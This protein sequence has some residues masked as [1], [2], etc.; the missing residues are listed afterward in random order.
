MNVKELLNTIRDNKDRL[1]TNAKLIDILDGNLLPYVKN[2]LSKELSTS[3]YDRSVG[4]IAPVNVFKK[5]VDKLTRLYSEGVIRST[6]ND[7]DKELL[8]Y[9]EEN[10]DLNQS[11]QFANKLFNA[12][13]YVALMPIV[14]DGR[15]VLKIIPADKFL[16]F[17]YSINNNNKIDLFVEISGEDQEGNVI[18]TAWTDTE[19]LVFDS[20]GN[21]RSEFMYEGGVN[22]YETIPVVYIGKSKISLMP[23]TDKGSFTLAK[24]PSILLTDLNYSVQY[25]SHSIIYGVDV[26]IAQASAN[27]DSLWILNSIEGERTSPSIGTITP[28]VDIDGVLKIIKEEIAMWFEARGVKTTST[29]TLNVNNAASGIAKMIDE[30]DTTQNI[31]E[32]AEIFKNAEGE[33]WELIKLMHNVWISSGFIVD[34][35]RAFSKDFNV[36]VSYKE[37]KPLVDMKTEIEKAKTLLELGLINKQDALR[38]VFPDLTDEQAA[39]KLSEIEAG[40]MKMIEAVNAA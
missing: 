40:R 16:V 21:I 31:K 28:N 32:Q 6:E 14:Y 20:N 4:R 37:I 18:Y 12:T 33:L 7:T 24:L 3:A 30:S 10:M 15:P 36:E 34:E 23:A 22:P 26:D 2:Q 1:E 17:N 13:G 5:L 8:A 35:A 9:Y 19:M 38:M 39:E 27:P 29:A 25:M 11:M